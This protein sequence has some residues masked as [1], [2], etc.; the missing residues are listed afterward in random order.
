MIDQ[1]LPMRTAYT[2]CLGK[3]CEEALFEKLQIVFPTGVGFAR[4]SLD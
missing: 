4:F 3:Y 1:Q 2:Q